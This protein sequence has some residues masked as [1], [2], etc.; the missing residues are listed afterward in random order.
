MPETVKVHIVADHITLWVDEGG[1]IHIKTRNPY[2]DPV[3]MN[4][5]EAEGL[6][7]VLQSLIAKARGP[8]PG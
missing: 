4:E 1:V 6:V 3:E 7:E 8:G 5:D 2:G